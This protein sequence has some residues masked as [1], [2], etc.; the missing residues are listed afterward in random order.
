MLAWRAYGRNNRKVMIHIHSLKKKSYSEDNGIIENDFK[1]KIT[2]YFVY[3]QAVT[4]FQHLSC[5]SYFL[6]Q[7]NDSVK[8]DST[9]YF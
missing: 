9:N 2:E 1:K 7:C 5:L 3:G 8:Q 4:V 6:M